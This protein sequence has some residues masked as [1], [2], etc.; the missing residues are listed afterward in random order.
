MIICLGGLL[1]DGRKQLANRLAMRFGLHHFDIDR[2][3]LREFSLDGTGNFKVLQPDTD[4]E[5]LR[6]Y[7]FALKEFS[8]LS[9]LH[10]TIIVDDTFHREIPREH[11]FSE[12]RK[13]YGPVIFIW[14][15]SDEISVGERLERLRKSGMTTS[16][17]EAE[18]RRERS[19]ALLQLPP[20]SVPR[21]FYTTYDKKQVLALWELIQNTAKGG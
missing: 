14:I 8:L 17:R 10:S 5:R 9:K 18:R 7:D 4:E 16:V 6:V 21:F 15:E 13:Y 3:K 11:F 1:G 19:R 12:A 20:P 2:K